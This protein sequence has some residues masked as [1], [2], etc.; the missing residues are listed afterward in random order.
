MNYINSQSL[1]PVVGPFSTAVSANNFLFLSGQVG[2]GPTGELAKTFEE[3]VV[4]VMENIGAI[5]L[6]NGLGFHDIVTV[7]V[8][9]KD[10]QKFSLLN[11]IYSRYFDNTYPARTCIAVADL[12]V[13][14]NVEITITAEQ[15]S[16]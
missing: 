5:L 12:P 9:L 7:T 15:K 10:M 8:Y 2:T 11:S 3:E 4:Q 16:L 1:A 6:E 14:A 13:M